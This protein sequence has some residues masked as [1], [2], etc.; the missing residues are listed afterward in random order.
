[1]IR[2]R[3][4]CNLFSRFSVAWALDPLP[5]SPV[6]GWWRTPLH[7]YLGAPAASLCRVT[8]LPLVP[9]AGVKPHT[10]PALGRWP[11]WGLPGIRSFLGCGRLVTV[12][13]LP[14]LL[15]G[16][17]PIGLSRQ[18]PCASPGLLP[19]LKWTAMQLFSNSLLSKLQVLFGRHR[20]FL[21][22][23]PWVT[24]FRLVSCEMEIQLIFHSGPASVGTARCSAW[25]T[26]PQLAEIGWQRPLCT[27]HL[28][29]RSR[30]R[31]DLQGTNLLF[32]ELAVA[33]E[34]SG[35]LWSRKM[36]VW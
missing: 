27:D 19:K 20:P 36:I 5:L 1:M 25:L 3:L 10:G 15:T 12:C 29:V 18:R 16:I 8:S 31:M 17:L 26:A 33:C 21:R 23:L 6:T 13:P 7:V 22:Y 34:L 35:A 30:G 11:W 2:V 14:V 24:C 32:D 28:S 9:E 4:D